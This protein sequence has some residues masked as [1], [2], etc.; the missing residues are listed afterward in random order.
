MG[1]DG[2]ANVGRG[3]KTGMAVHDPAT[4]TG[5]EEEKLAVFR[6]VR[7]DLRRLADELIA[8]A[9]ARERQMHADATKT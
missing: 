3:Q 6:R 8:Q 7:D 4:A 5:T 1:C 9:S 2:R